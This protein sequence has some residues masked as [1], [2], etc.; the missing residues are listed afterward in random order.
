MAFIIEEYRDNG[1]RV[2]RIRP[3]L[4]NETCTYFDRA[5]EQRKAARGSNVGVRQRVRVKD[6]VPVVSHVVAEAR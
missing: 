2:M 4:K 3:R 6:D 5:R 1:S